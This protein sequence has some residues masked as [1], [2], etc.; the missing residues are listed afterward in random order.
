MY[1]KKIRKSKIKYIHSTN[2]STKQKLLICCQSKS[3]LWSLGSNGATFLSSGL[4][5]KQRVELTKI[6]CV[7]YISFITKESRSG[8]FSAAEL[9]FSVQLTKMLQRCFRSLQS[10]GTSFW[11]PVEQKRFI[12]YQKPKT[13]LFFFLFFQ[14]FPVKKKSRNPLSGLFEGSLEQSIC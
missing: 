6:M 2:M 12:Q 13:F 5:R 10:N 9:L 3:P 11:S 14:F 1:I 4:Y 7:S 8:F